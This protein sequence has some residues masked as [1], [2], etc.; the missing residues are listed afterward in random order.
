MTV[1]LIE[2]LAALWYIPYPSLISGLCPSLWFSF[3]EKLNTSKHLNYSAHSYRCWYGK[4]YY[5]KKWYCKIRNNSFSPVGRYTCIYISIYR[6]MVTATLRV[7]SKCVFG[8]NKESQIWDSSHCPFIVNT[9]FLL[10]LYSYENC[11]QKR[12][13]QVNFCIFKEIEIFGHTCDIFSLRPTVFNI[14]K[15]FRPS[16]KILKY[17]LKWAKM[18]T[19]YA[20]TVGTGKSESFAAGWSWGGILHMG[21]GGVGEERE[22]MTVKAFSQKYRNV[23]GI[24]VNATI[25][26]NFNGSFMVP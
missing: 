6:Y 26:F 1:S 12:K 14:K 7:T 24:K 9:K 20:R 4:I 13:P 15:K 5:G 21:S 3:N 10:I 25:Y 8:W 11:S 22:L 19:L 2:H 17:F 18:R 23:T 16:S